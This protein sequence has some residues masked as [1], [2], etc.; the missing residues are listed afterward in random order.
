[1]DPG[2]ENHQQGDGAVDHLKEDALR[3]GRAPT[4][5]R[6]WRKIVVPIRDRVTPSGELGAG[7]WKRDGRI[8]PSRFD[9][10]F[11]GRFHG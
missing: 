6:V 2:F 4:S 8:E 9:D 10:F 11:S 7:S 5:L 3:R 1:M